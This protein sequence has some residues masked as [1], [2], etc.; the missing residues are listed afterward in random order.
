[1]SA[2]FEGSFARVKQL[3][4][5]F[6]AN[7]KFLSHPSIKKMRGSAAKNTEL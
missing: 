5:T 6:K 4:A 7:K 2:N 3:A 1:M